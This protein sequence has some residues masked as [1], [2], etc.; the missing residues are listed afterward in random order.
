MNI[1]QYVKDYGNWNFDER[2]FNEV[3]SLIFSELSYLDFSF[4]ATEDDFTT[5]LSSSYDYAHKIC[6]NSV[7][8]RDSE[9]LLKS[10]CDSKRFSSVRIG[11]YKEI[12]NNIEPMHFAAV[13]FEFNNMIYAALQL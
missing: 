7:H 3:D 12:I 2:S 13:S 8:P 9:K 10:M 5:Q 11:Y 6:I 1:I 4:I